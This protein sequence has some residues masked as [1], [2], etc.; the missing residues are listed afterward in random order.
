MSR[1]RFEGETSRIQVSNFTALVSLL[2][3]YDGMEKSALG[4]ASLLVIFASVKPVSKQWENETREFTSW[5][6]ARK[7]RPIP[8]SC[9]S[10]RLWNNIN[11]QLD[12]TI[13]V[14]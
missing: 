5:F 1:L 11:N 12:A 3:T 7:K 14:Y 10:I 2:G 9:L 4:E 8:S 6:S 13:T